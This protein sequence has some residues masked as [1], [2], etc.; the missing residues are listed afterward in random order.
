[1]KSLSRWLWAVLLVGGF[2]L[3]PG[4]STLAQTYTATLTGNV[5][6]PQG[7]AVPNVKV[8][9]TNQGT[10]LAYNAQTSDTG[11]YTIP[12]LPVGTY[13]ISI[14]ATGFK[15]LVSNEIKLEI[16]QTARVNLQLQVGQVSEVVNIQDVAPV[17][18]TENVTVGQVITG[19]QSAAQR[20]EFSATR[21]VGS[22]RGD[23]EPR[24]VHGRGTG[25]AGP[26]L[27]QRQ[28]RTRQCFPARRRVRG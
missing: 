13:V 18:Q 12:F 16:N 17:L 15:K 1:M 10:G 23:A 27:R 11:V 20:P 3:S 8:T 7:A 14:E 6:D 2:V 5:S 9:A 25:R 28:P 19:H 4:V 22:G 24:R 26:S 21:A